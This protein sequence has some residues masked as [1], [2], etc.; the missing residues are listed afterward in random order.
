MRGAAS[1]HVANIGGAQ[2]KLSAIASMSSSAVSVASSAALSQVRPFC[3]QTCE[4]VSDGMPR[5]D[6]LRTGGVASMSVKS[7][8][9][10]PPMG[11]WCGV[12]DAGAFGQ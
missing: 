2:R 7:P 1:V 4:H 11:S 10:M 9:G 6:H 5:Y 3:A 8:L 12:A